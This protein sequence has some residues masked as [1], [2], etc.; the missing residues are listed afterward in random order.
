MNLV[1]LFALA[2][3]MAVGFRRAKVGAIWDTRTAAA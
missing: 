1:E 3:G 2:G